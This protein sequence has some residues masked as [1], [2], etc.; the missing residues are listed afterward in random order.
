MRR[1]KKLQRVA[2]RFDNDACKRFTEVGEFGFLS[3]SYVHW[4]PQEPTETDPNRLLSLGGISPWSVQNFG[5]SNGSKFP[6]TRERVPLLFRVSSK[7]VSLL[8]AI[9]LTRNA[10]W[11]NS[12]SGALMPCSLSQKKIDRVTLFSLLLSSVVHTCVWEEKNW[13]SVIP[14]IRSLL[15]ASGRL[16]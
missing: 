15:H 3:F 16:P 14:S 13:K 6:T 7:R 5:P 1:I 10:V 12:K 2:I 9:Y 8:S 11:R 4:T